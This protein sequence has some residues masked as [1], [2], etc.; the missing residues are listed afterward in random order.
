[1][2]ALV[3]TVAEWLW[4]EDEFVVSIRRSK[5]VPRP[6]LL[7]FGASRGCQYNNG[8]LTTLYA[9]SEVVNGRRVAGA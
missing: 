4:P 9:L 7:R 8:M 2:V 3:G 5:R 6:D 1:M